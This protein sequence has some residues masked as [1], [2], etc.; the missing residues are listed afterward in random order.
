MQYTTG[1]VAASSKVILSGTLKVKC[2]CVSTM[3]DIALDKDIP[4]MR[5]PFCFLPENSIPSKH[6]NLQ[7]S[8]SKMDTKFENY[9]DRWFFFLIKLFVY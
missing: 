9:L 8:L 6:F 7:N 3:V 2:E 1:I 5:S 4:A